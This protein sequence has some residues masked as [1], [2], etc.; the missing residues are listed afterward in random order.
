VRFR[1]EFRSNKGI[2]RGTAETA[3][4]AE[5][6]GF[7]ASSAGSAVFMFG[8]EQSVAAEDLVDQGEAIAVDRR[9]REEIDFYG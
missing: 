6:R 5:A 9:L 1:R 2:G 3:E 8:S 4:D 7:S